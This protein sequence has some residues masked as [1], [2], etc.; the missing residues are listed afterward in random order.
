MKLDEAI[1]L[2]KKS[3][4]LVEFVQTSVPLDTLIRLLKKEF[5][6]QFTDVTTEKRSFIVLKG[7]EKLTLQKARQIANFI[8]KYGYK[9][10]NYSA[11][12]INI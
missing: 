5:G 7:D 11:E 10:D 3:N 9:L 4:Y 2:L 1:N 6:I 12:R 8:K